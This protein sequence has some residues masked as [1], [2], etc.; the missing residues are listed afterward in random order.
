MIYVIDALIF[1]NILHSKGK[2]RVFIHVIAFFSYCFMFCW[3]FE[4]NLFVSYFI[5][6]ISFFILGEFFLQ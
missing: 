2:A 1:N 3:D 4:V 5:F 6:L